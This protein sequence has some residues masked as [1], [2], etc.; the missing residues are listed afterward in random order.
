MGGDDGGDG[1]DDGNDDDEDF[2]LNLSRNV[3]KLTSYASLTV[4]Y[5]SEGSLSLSVTSLNAV[6]LAASP[7]VLKGGDIQITK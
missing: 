4:S 5:S 6:G 3:G 1:G 2:E 7:C